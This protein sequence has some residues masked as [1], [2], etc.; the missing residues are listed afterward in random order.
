MKSAKEHYETHLASVYE[1]MVGG[2]VAATAQ[3]D[4]EIEALG[5]PVHRGDAI[6][7]LGAGLGMH[8][9]PLAR[10]GARVTAVDS[11]TALLSRLRELCGELPIRTIQTDLIE[12]LRTDVEEYA[13]ILCMGDTIT[14][15]D[16]PQTAED[17]LGLA[18]QRLTAGGTLILTFRDYSGELLNEGRFIPVRSDHERILTCFLEYERSFVS[19][20]DIIHEKTDG[21]WQM[22]VS[23]YKKQRLNPQQ[24]TSTLKRVGFDARQESG[25]RGLVRVVAQKPSCTQTNFEMVAPA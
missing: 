20:H 14:H 12:F 5:L 1:W 4:S 18:H 17:L 15:L 19:V 2:G 13:A 7:D 9:I 21:G 16:S 8:A 6:L 22:R 11:S 24:L 23:S 25:M 3:G 10:R